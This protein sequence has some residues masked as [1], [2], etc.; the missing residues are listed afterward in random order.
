MYEESNDRTVKPKGM[1]LF[2]M[3]VKVIVIQCKVVLLTYL[4]AILYTQMKM[5]IIVYCV[6]GDWRISQYR[7]AIKWR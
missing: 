5:W 4:K 7:H 2:E 6:T 3:I 1:Y